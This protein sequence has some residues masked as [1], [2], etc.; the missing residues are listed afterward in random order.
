MPTLRCTSPR[1]GSSFST[2]IAAVR[3]VCPVM[4]AL[5]F[6]CASF[7]SA[8]LLFRLHQCGTAT[9]TTKTE[10]CQASVLP[11]RRRVL[12]S[13]QG[14]PFGDCGHLNYSWSRI[15]EIVTLGY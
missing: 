4:P 1:G 2:E 3:L 12:L 6:A 7:G 13:P 11:T 15:R 8:A 14:A 5:H 9:I 10:G